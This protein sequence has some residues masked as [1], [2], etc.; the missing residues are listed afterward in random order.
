MLRML[1]NVGKFL[2]SFTIIV[3][4]T[5]AIWMIVAPQDAQDTFVALVTTAGGATPV[6]AHVRPTVSEG[7]AI[8]QPR[9]S[10]ELQSNAVA[11]DPRKHQ[12]ILRLPFGGFKLQW[13]IDGR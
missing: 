10:A 1:S 6:V 2:A 7:R 12:I 5:S 4:V 13:E 9:S 8:V 3:G 11:D